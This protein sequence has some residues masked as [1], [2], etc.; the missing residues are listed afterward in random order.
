M[1]RGSRA[2]L[3]ASTRGSTTGRATTGRTNG[4]ARRPPGCRGSRR[5]RLRLRAQP[6]PTTPSHHPIAGRRS[7]RST[8]RRPRDRRRQLPGSVRG[9]R[10]RGDRQPVRPEARARAGA[11]AGC[12]A[13]APAPRP[14]AGRVRE[15]RQGARGGWRARRVLPV[16]AAVRLSARAAGARPVPEAP[17]LA[18]AGGDHVHRHDLGGPR[19]GVWRRRSSRPSSRTSTARGFSAVEAYPEPEARADATSAA[20]PAFWRACGFELAVDDERFPVVRREL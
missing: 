18:A 5:R 10:R 20:N 1:Q 4:A 6:S 12:A 13:Q 2:F 17:E 8:R 7:T 15:L 14:R 9:R 11:R 3:P 19:Q 16:R